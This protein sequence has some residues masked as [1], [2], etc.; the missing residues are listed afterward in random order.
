MSATAKNAALAIV[1]VLLILGAG[2]LVLGALD[3]SSKRLES[4]IS[5]MENRMQSGDWKG[6]KESLQILESD[7]SKI[8]GT[9]AMLID[10]IEIDNIDTSLSRA[11]QYIET[12]QYSLA[13]AEASVLKQFVRHI[14]K[15]EG[16]NLENIF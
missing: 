9:W 12:Q 7:W 3:Q 13:L 5:L 4:H 8:K 11:K 10:H 2:I 14:P 1:L 16:F 6:A 15:K